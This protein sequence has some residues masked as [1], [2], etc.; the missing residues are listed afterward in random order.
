[1]KD[2]DIVELYFARDEQAIAET[3]KKYGKLC[4]RIAH[5]ITGDEYDADEC[6]NDTYL[7][8]WRAIPPTRPISL[9]A[10]A[11][12]I[13]RN[14]AIG[15][16]K[17]RKAAKRQ[18]EALLSLSELEDIIPDTDGFENI[19]DREVGRWISDFLYGEAEE[20]RIIFVRK[21]WYFDSVAQLA[22]RYGY[23]EAKI[24][25][26]LFR[27]RNKLRVYLEEKGVAL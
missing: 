7:G 1:M 24:K 5:R 15:R 21:Y 16:L 19:D 11:A 3:D 13:A 10:F 18:C 14:S 12:R 27:T 2:D 9:A 26:V 17:Y 23:S 22:E 8:L 6:V 25:S 4:R 20:T